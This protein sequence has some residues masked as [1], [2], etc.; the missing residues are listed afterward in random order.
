M[1]DDPFT[2]VLK[3]IWTLLESNS[4]ITSLVR[5]ANRLKLWDGNLDP[6]VLNPET[7]L[8]ETDL[9]MI[10]I[11]PA[12]GTMNPVHTST[13]AMAEQVYRIKMIDGNLLINSVYFPLKWAIFKALANIDNLLGLTYV[14]G[15][16]IEDSS[17]ER[18]FEGHPGWSLGI[19]IKITMMWSRTVL[20]S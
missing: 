14:R 15:I 8:T 5:V 13:G 10:I 3:N 12:G 6:E 16:L 18:N 20:K 19:D 9:P 17:E 1:A 2:E 7:G 4:E 11:E